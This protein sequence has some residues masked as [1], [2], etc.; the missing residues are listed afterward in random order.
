MPRWVTLLCVESIANA[1][2]ARNLHRCSHFGEFLAKRCDVHVHHARGNAR[3]VVPHVLENLRAS[4]QTPLRFGEEPKQTEFERRQ[5]D[6]LAVVVEG[7]EIAYE[8]RRADLQNAGIFFFLEIF[9]TPAQE[10]R[11]TRHELV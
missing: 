2:D 4:K 9:L 11:D 5:R 7:M 1:A 3:R 10:R 8:L 6:A